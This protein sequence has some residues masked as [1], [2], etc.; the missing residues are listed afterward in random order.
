[1]KMKIV[2]FYFKYLN[3]NSNFV[4]F[5]LGAL[6][7]AAVLLHKPRD[8]KLS[9]NQHADRTTCDGVVRGATVNNVM[10]MCAVSELVPCAAR[11]CKLHLGRI[12]RG[13]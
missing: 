2:P 10:A 4:L 1:M 8:S 7:S 11:R 13:V 12:F 9:P 5:T 6:I 3:N